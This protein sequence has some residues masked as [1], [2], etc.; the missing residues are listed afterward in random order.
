VP[1]FALKVLYGE[2]AEILTKG[3]NVVPDRTSRL[4][5]VFAHTELESALRSAL[6]R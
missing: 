1:A 2:M 6:N 5:Y 4:G 3:Q